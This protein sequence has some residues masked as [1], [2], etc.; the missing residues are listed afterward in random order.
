MHHHLYFY[1]FI[2]NRFPL[3]I[4]G[5]ERELEGRK[6]DL[7]LSEASLNHFPKS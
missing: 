7:C 6:N 4:S 3:E 2:F 5:D 1:V